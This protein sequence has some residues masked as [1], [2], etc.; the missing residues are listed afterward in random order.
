MW[1]VALA[2]LGYILFMAVTHTSFDGDDSYYVVQ[3]LIAQ[4]T[5]SM[6]TVEPYTGGSTTMDVRHAMAVFTMWVAYMASVS[7]IHVTI[8]CHS[9][10]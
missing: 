8:F 2:L 4:E 5:G 6:Y 9:V 7:G 3:S 10:S 1:I